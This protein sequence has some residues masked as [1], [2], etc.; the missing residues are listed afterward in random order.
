MASCS[1]ALC[2]QHL[3][4]PRLQDLPCWGSWVSSAQRSNLRRG[5]C[6]SFP[7]NIKNLP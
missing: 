5:I 2:C 4:P 1:R 3:Q 6:H 7:L